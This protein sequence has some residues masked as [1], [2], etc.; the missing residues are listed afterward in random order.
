LTAHTIS[1]GTTG[2]FALG[3]FDTLAVL[4][5]VGEIVNGS[6]QYTPIGA[7]GS[8]WNFVGVGDYDGKSASEFLMHNSNS[9]ALVIGTVSAGTVSYQAVGGV[10]P[11]W[12]FHTST[13]ATLS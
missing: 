4:S 3:S 6:A 5:G 9:G 8:E 1:P 12:N 2:T 10:G 7:V 13:V 11:E